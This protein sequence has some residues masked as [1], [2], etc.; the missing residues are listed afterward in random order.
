MT[1]EFHPPFQIDPYAQTQSQRSLANFNQT[2]SNIG[3]QADNYKKQKLDQIQRQRENQRQ[4]AMQRLQEA[5]GQR[6]AQAFGP[7]DPTAW[8]GASSPDMSSSGG[9]S[10]SAGTS[11]GTFGSQPQTPPNTGFSPMGQPMSMPSQ[12]GQAMH[13][14]GT[15]LTS[16]FN[17]WMQSGQPSTYD[18]PEMGGTGQGVG[19]RQNPMQPQ[20]SPGFDQNAFMRMN[21]PQRT[22]YIGMQDEV[23][24]QRED[25]D[26]YGSGGANSLYSTPE[27]AA[28]QL[29][30]NDPVKQKNLVAQLNTLYPGGKVPR[31][32]I[33]ST[34]GGLHFDVSQGEKGSQFTDKRMT[35]LG[36]ALDPS[37]QRGGAFGVSKQVFDRAERMETL[38]NAYKDGNLDSRQIEEMAIGLNAMLSG[39]NTGA[40]EQVKSLVP[41]TI[42]GNTQKFKE[43]LTN[44]PQGLQQQAFVQRMLGSIG[45]EKATAGDQMKRTQFQRIARYAD[46][47]NKDRDGFENTLRS[48]GV[49]PDEYRSWK[50]SGYKPM[51]AV[52]TPGDGGKTPRSDGKVQ[53]SNGKESLW[54][55]PNDA[56]A[57]A[58]DGYQ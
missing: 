9:A 40:S 33:A 4:D 39:A 57:A 19:M 27:Q 58:K 13:A 24:K 49:D 42:V 16:H 18:H 11:Q 8:G 32:A 36:D 44:D 26:K 45:R 56:A 54:I 10:P 23:R 34:G 37:K 7:I 29:A 15:D 55:D 30:P 52:Q 50:K 20:A 51:S 2:L 47:E 17:N 53:V 21:A 28:F 41:R 38:A 3:D 46:L 22:A 35:Q 12:P 5:Q 43:W 14:P 25:A 31:S 48:S 6:E 1:L